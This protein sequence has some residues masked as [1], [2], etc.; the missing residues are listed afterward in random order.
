MQNFVTGIMMLALTAGL[1]IIYL[2]NNRSKLKKAIQKGSKNL[3][4]N[5]IRIFAIFV[6]IGILQNFLSKEA[7]SNFLIRFSGLKGVFAGAVTGAIMMGPVATGYP[8]GKYLLENGGTVALASSFLASWVMVGVISIPLELKNF[9][10]R[11]TIT[12]N[13]FAFISVIII[14][15]IM[16][17][18][19]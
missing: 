17:V 19:L 3:I 6:I 8:I 18:L 7:V 10:K 9:G 12:R 4:Q 11:F 15:L 14:A 16:E 13:L 5:S 1:Y 2:R